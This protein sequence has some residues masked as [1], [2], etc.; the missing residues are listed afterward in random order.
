VC[1]VRLAIAKIICKP[2]LRANAEGDFESA[3]LS[4]AQNMTPVNGI[5]FDSCV[6]QIGDD[7]QRSESSSP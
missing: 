1:E 7:G 6:L 4:A 5:S 3:L 2:K